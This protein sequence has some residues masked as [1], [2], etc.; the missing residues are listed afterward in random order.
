MD[1][2]DDLAGRLVDIGNDVGDQGVRKPLTRTHGHAWR[3]PC[4]LEIV[5][6]TGEVWRHDDRF[7]RPHRLQRAEN[8]SSNRGVDPQAAE[9]EAPGQSQHLVRTLTPIDGLSRWTTR[10]TY[11]QVPPAAAT[12]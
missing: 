1:C 6:Q 9:C 2:Q 8:H 3:V 5:R 7:R 10:V 11:H 4:D 12:G